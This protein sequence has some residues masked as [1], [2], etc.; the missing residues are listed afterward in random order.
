MNQLN[1]KLVGAAFDLLIAIILIVLWFV[2]VEE[3]S[4]GL[5]LKC[6]LL[7]CVSVGYLIAWFKRT[8]SVK[9]LFLFFFMYS[10]LTNAGQLFLSVFSV[11]IIYTF[12]VFDIT[13]SRVLSKTIDYQMMCTIM[14][15]T[16]ALISHRF[17]ALPLQ[18]K[19]MTFE[20]QS[21]LNRE[22][23]WSIQDM[24]YVILGVVYFFLNVLRLGSRVDQVYLDAFNSGESYSVPF[25]L[26]FAFY[27]LMYYA[28]YAHRVKG[29]PFRKVIIVINI[30]VGLSNIL[31]GSRNVIIPLVFGMLFLW[32]YDFKKITFRK[33]IGI[34]LIGI[35]S[36]YLLGAFVNLRRVS[37]SS[38]SFSFIFDALFGVNLSEQIAMTMSEMG[39]SLRVLTTTISEIDRGIVKSE[40]TF[41][42]TIL[43]GI[44]PQVDILEF[45]GITEPER[46]R[47]SEWI[48]VSH[49]SN[50]GWGY[51]MYAEAYYNFKEFGCIFMGL[52]GYVY[53]WLENKIEK[54]YLEGWAVMASAW[55][56]AAVYVIFL[57]RADSLLFVTRLRYS[58]YFGIACMILRGRVKIPKGRVTFK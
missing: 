24:L 10:T 1:K 30:M 36:I 55:L 20:V 43:K 40:P 50:A 8:H 12:D 37:L 25:I 11:D 42:Y 23:G 7:L 47:L 29:D 33:K 27:I 38:L 49:G 15:C 58:L 16:G 22:A 54:W 18:A 35:V 17:N 2:F 53:V 39:G 44:V 34:V 56:F 31:Y 52:F 48:T 45:L 28:C 13:D 3:F 41:L 6:L 51:S 46:W 4:E 21:S 32:S 5:W 26:Q 9:S 14:M 19:K 57:A